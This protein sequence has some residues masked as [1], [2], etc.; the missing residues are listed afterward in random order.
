MLSPRG[1]YQSQTALLTG[2]LVLCGLRF[3]TQQI[4]L[5]KCPTT[6]VPVIS[7]WGSVCW[8]YAPV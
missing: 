2:S 7:L 1:V 4:N 5:S 3:P 6:T 8:R